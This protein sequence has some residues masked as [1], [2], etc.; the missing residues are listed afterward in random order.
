MQVVRKGRVSSFGMAILT[1]IDSTHQLVW[2]ITASVLIFGF[3]YIGFGFSFWV[4]DRY[5]I[6]SRQMSALALAR[7][8]G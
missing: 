3:G 4:L 5:R 2:S 8:V 1:Q 7:H 6:H